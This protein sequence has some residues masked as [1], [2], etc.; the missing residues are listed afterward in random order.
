VQPRSDEETGN[1]WL[2]GEDLA[3]ALLL[4]GTPASRDTVDAAIQQLRNFLPG[5]ISGK[6][7]LQEILAIN[8]FAEGLRVDG[9]PA[10]PSAPSTASV[11]R[12]PQKSPAKMAPVPNPLSTSIEF[13]AN[14]TRNQQLSHSTWRLPYRGKAAPISK[15]AIKEEFRRLDILAEGRLTLLNLRSALQLREVQESEQDVRDWF[16][17]HDRGG[18]GYID[19]KDYEAIYEASSK[20]RGLKTATFSGVD[21]FAEEKSPSRPDSPSA[22]KR[23]AAED[24]VKLLKKTFDSLDVDGDGKISMEDLRKAFTTKGKAFTPSDLRTWV[25]TRDLSG[26]GAVS[27]EDFA[28]N[29]K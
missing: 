9:E 5:I 20:P 11:L 19:F 25:Q 28:K 2:K 26:T 24:R 10:A 7:C 14:E 21:S 17:E 12:A 27:F 15:A 18:K 1:V 3:D 6:F 16:R 8:E 13:K 22:L 29:F 4:A 23:R